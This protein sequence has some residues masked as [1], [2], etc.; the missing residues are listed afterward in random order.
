MIIVSS[1]GWLN[2]SSQTFAGTTDCFWPSSLKS[3][4]REE[5]GGGGA[6][7]RGMSDA[8][9]NNHN[10]EEEK[11]KASPEKE[12][13]VLIFPKASIKRIMKIDPETRQISSVSSVPQPFHP[14]CLIGGL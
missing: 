1:R 7:E 6:R 8:E 5:E 4:L 14:C 3:Q 11:A 12:E 10:R 13:A 2:N 9:D